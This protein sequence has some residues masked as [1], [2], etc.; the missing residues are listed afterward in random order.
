[1]VEKMADYYRAIDVFCLASKKEG[2]PLS[3]LETQASGRNVVLTDVGGCSET[4][5]PNQGMLVPAGNAEPLV[6]ALLEQL[7]K[8]CS[9]TAR[10]EARQFVLEH[11]DL[12]RM[13]REYGQ[14]YEGSTS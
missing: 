8:G 13:L 4:I 5:A 12:S 14:L 10:G 2:L 6:R 3:A 7:E 1:M 9:E 11:G